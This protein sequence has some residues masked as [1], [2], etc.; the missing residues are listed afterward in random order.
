MN[1]KGVSPVIATVLLI[2]IVIVLAAIIF[3]WFR[4][5]TQEAII[6]FEKNIELVC[7]DV[8]FAASYSEGVLA[9]SNDGNVPIFQMKA[10]ISGDGDYETK[11]LIDYGWPDNGLNQGGIFSESV[12]FVGANQVILSPVLIGKTEKGGDRTFACDENRYGYEIII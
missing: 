8:K 1:K 12:D 9:V 7:D 3:M 5:M 11:N 6:K 10:K 2:G 4:G